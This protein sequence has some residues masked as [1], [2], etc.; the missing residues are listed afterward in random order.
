[1]EEIMMT[2]TLSRMRSMSR[3]NLHLAL[4]SLV[5]VG[6]N[7]CNTI[8]NSMAPEFRREN[9]YFFHMNEFWAT[10]CF[11]LVQVYAL[12]GCPRDLRDIFSRPN[13]VK[14]IMI[15]N[16]V[17]TVVPALLVTASLENFEVPS[18]EIEYVNEITMAVVDFVFLYSMA[19]KAKLMADS[20]LFFNLVVTAIAMAIA[21][22]QLCIYNG[23]PGDIA[24][25]V[26]HYFEF[27]F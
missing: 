21:V 11:A 1:M 16:V 26:A 15:I 25:Q 18:H 24:E 8:L 27:T 12:V 6:I 5:Y 10:F 14:L 17:A 22:S 13:L 7:I 2:E 4:C 3:T 23:L 20:G 19:K 9:K